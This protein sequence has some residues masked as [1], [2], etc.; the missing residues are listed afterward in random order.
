MEEAASE[1]WR[2]GKE[3]RARRFAEHWG[4]KREL[5]NLRGNLSKVTFT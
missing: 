5:N 4:S 1:D 2:A 3:F